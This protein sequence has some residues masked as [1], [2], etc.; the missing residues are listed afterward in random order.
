M[1]DRYIDLTP[2][3]AQELG[4]AK[5]HVMELAATMNAERIGPYV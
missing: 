1:I 5:R 2:E 3:K 4:N